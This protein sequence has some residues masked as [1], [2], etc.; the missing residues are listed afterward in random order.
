MKDTKRTSFDLE[1][2]NS[3]N[4]KDFADKMGSNLSNVINYMLRIMLAASPEVKRS[5]AN[6]C[7]AQREELKAKAEGMSAFEKQDML[8]TQREYQDLAYFFSVGL[9][10]SQTRGADPMRKV[11]LKEGYVLI[12]SDPDWILLD[13]F[14]DPKECMYAGVV[15]IRQPLDGSKTY[16]AKHYVFCCNYRYGNEYPSEMDDEVYSAACEKDPA[17]KDILNAV[18]PAKYNGKECFANMVN[19]KEYSAAPTP[20][21]FHI[22]EQGDPIYWNK[23]D[24]DFEPP[25]GCM[26]VRK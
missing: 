6:F 10:A 7:N 14:K 13:N 16:D 8:K 4:L 5:L 9:D 22:V 1:V 19:V 12:P 2:G 26:I 3:D 20:G 25:Y 11:Y 23:L 18:V 15:E 17:F 24:P 21:L